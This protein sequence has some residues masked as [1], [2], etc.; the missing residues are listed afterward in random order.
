MANIRLDAVG[1]KNA[2]AGQAG[3]LVLLK[4][5]VVVSELGYVDGIGAD[6]VNDSV[7]V[8]DTARPVP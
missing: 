6:L 1:L 2:L 4:Y 3:S 7:L 8:I 5:S